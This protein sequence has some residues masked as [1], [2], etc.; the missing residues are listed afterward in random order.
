VL[1]SK[2]DK[3]IAE[4][5]NQIA[6][7][8]VQQAHALSVVT[9]QLQIRSKEVQSL[10]VKLLCLAGPGLPAPSR[11]L[12]GGHTAPTQRRI[13]AEL[14]TF[15]EHRSATPEARKQALYEHF[16]RH[17]QLPT[18]ITAQSI[19]LANFQK[20]CRENPEWAHLIRRDV[21]EKIEEFWTL[22]KCLSIQIHCKVGHA[23]K[24]QHL[25]N[26]SAKEYSEAK[27]QWE[28]KELFEKGSGVF[29]LKCKSKNSVT[30]LRDDI[31]ETNSLLQNEAGT[32]CWLDLNLMVEETL[33]D[34]RLNGYLQTTD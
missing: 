34:E 25:I 29:L 13:A 1:Q 33:R 6:D 24:Y 2:F 27:K 15:L 20:V 12:L 23:E 32:A 10:K 21:I 30:G 3:Y 5:R 22:E 19:T 28:H 16:Q 9:R 4:T 7:L 17:P 14:Q 26:I 8:K 31:V 11:P 18:A